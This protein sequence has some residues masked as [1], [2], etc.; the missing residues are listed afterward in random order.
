MNLFGRF[1]S[2]LSSF[3]DGIDKE[4]LI[5]LLK[6]DDLNV[7]YEE[8]VCILFLLTNQCNIT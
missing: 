5:Q 3:L 8:D 4:L 2:K 7:S 6:D 1:I